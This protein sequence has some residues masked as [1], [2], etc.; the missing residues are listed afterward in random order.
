MRECSLSVT[1]MRT[2][3]SCT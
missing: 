2:H 1:Y 3:L